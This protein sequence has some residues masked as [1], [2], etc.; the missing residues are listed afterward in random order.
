VGI[1]EVY[2]ADGSASSLVN[3]SCRARVGTGADV[4][5]A[6]FVISGSESK[7]VLIRGVGPTLST[8][9]VP[10]TLADPQL[11]VI[12]QGAPAATATVASNDNWDAALASTF[13]GIGAFGLTAG[14]RDAAL[15]VTLPPGSYTAQV[16]GVGNTTGVAIVE[17]YELP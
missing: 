10:G 15:V 11:H 5:I 13:S 2:D 9:G 8:L 4:L 14:S 7:R 3:L 12:R 1:V 17:V 6:G 16:S